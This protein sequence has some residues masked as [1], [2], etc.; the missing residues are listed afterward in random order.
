M[1]K[2]WLGV[3]LVALG[4]LIW[5]AAL[6]LFV[7]PAHLRDVNFPHFEARLLAIVSAG[8]SVASGIILIIA[9]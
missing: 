9:D 5:A 8:A 7:T 3:G 1:R 2:K 4:L 6:T